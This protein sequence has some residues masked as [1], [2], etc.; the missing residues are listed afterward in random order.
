MRRCLGAKDSDLGMSP[1][2]TH[3]ILEVEPARPYARRTPP[4]A[5]S[6]GT[7]PPAAER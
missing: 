3:F 2:V 5:T 6:N 1:G 4:P 7:P